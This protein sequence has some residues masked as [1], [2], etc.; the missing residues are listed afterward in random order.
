[1]WLE[2]I[3]WNTKQTTKPAAQELD[4]AYGDLIANIDGLAPSDELLAE[5]RAQLDAMLSK[6]PSNPRLETEQIDL[7]DEATVTAL[8]GEAK[9]FLIA[10][11]LEGNDVSSAYSGDGGVA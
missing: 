5:V 3:K 10:R 2:K 6:L 9:E 7:D 11:L 1:M 4:A 8:I